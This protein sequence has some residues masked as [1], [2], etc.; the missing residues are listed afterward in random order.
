MLLAGLVAASVTVWLASE[1]PSNEG[2]DWLAPTSHAERGV[3]MPQNALVELDGPMREDALKR[4]AATPFIAAEGR[5]ALIPQCR[6]G[7]VARAVRFQRRGEPLLAFFN[8]GSLTITQSILTHS[9]PGI[10]KTAVAV[11]TPA[12]VERVFDAVSAAE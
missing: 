6:H 11:C 1:K 8:Q 12:P 4:L 3:Q 9:D 2:E 10:E 5:F 7:Y